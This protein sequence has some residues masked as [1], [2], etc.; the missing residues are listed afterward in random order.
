MGLARIRRRSVSRSPMSTKA[1]SV[2]LST[3]TRRLITVVE[4][5]AIGT[6]LGITAL[7]SDPDGTDVV[8]YSLTNDAGGRFAI[9]AN[10]GVVTVAGA[11]DREAA[12]SLQHHYS[13]HQHGHFLHIAD[14]D[15]QHQRR[16]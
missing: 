15:N 2:P 7:A 16:E 8:T 13:S 5:S 6:T 4:N 10:T 3:A 12:A 11:I 14:G 9:D 1:V